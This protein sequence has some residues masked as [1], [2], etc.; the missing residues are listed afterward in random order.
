MTVRAIFASDIQGGIGKNG[1]LPWPKNSADLKWFKEST[2]HSIV[3]M[4]K[5]TWLDPKLPKPLPNRY[6]VVVSDSGIDSIDTRPN[7]LI[8]RDKVKNFI[9]SIDQDI[10]IIGGAVLL[11]SSI[12][13][14]EELWVS[15]ITEKYDCDTY[16]T[17]NEED[18]VMFEDL[19]YFDKKLFIEK[20]KRVK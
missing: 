8:S 14:V 19:A 10:W 1:T 20:Y 15:R 9:D 5:N 7:V 12:Q 3:L 18:F 4:G 6:N 2:E 17:F 13:Y 11:N 16:L